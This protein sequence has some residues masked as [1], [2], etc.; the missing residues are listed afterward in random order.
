LIIFLDNAPAYCD[1]DRSSVIVQA[2]GVIAQWLAHML[3]AS[4]FPGLIHSTPKL[5]QVKRWYC[6]NSSAL[7]VL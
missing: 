4:T 6:H 2:T 1:Y 5:F 7:L 3:P